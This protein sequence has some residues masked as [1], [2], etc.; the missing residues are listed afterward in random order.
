MRWATS[1]RSCGTRWPSSST[2]PNERVARP[3][4][5]GGCACTGA[6]REDIG[7]RLWTMFRSVSSEVISVTVER[8]KACFTLCRGCSARARAKSF[9]L[10]PSVVTSCSTSLKSDSASEDDTGDDSVFEDGESAGG[11]GA[12]LAIA[13]DLPPL[14]YSCL[15]STGRSCIGDAR[16]GKERLVAVSALQTF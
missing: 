6:G 3:L 2:L 4:S 16:K 12:A 1:R 9:S 7:G 10:P 8:L 5:T 14:R 13:G 15:R 11:A